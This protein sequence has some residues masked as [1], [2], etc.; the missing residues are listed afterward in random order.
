M[1]QEEDIRRA[2]RERIELQKDEMRQRIFTAQREHE[3]RFLHQQEMEEAQRKQLGWECDLKY[4]HYRRMDEFQKR[5][6]L[7]RMQL[8]REDQAFNHKLKREASK[9]RL[10]MRRVEY[11][12]E[13]K[14]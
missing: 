9:R 6:S 11:E 12:L 7:Q 14:E 4:E 3:C 5:E 2:K 13:V 1:R 10:E 8:L